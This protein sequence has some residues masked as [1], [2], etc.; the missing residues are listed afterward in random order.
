MRHTELFSSKWTVN[1]LYPTH[2]R[3]PIK[4]GFYTPS[5][6]QILKLG[7]YTSADDKTPETLSILPMC[8]DD[9]IGRGSVI[10]REKKSELLRF[11]ERNLG[12]AIK[13]RKSIV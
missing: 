7:H 12:G 3:G 10:E 5:Q 8:I 4:I 6:I 1:C 2:N 13:F 9:H 11:Y